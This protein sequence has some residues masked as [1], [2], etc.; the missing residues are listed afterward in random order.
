LEASK[1]SQQGGYNKVASESVG[2]RIAIL[3]LMSPWGNGRKS[4][5]FRR[6]L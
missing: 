1:Q 5:A 3:I 2:R 4:L 6:T